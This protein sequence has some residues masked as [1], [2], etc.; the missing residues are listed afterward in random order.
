MPAAKFCSSRSLQSELESQSDAPARCQLSTS[1]HGA[2]SHGPRGRILAFRKLFPG[3]WFQTFKFAMVEDLI[4]SPPFT[5][6]LS[7]LREKGEMWDGPLVPHLAAPGARQI[8]RLGEGQQVAVLHRASLPPLL[9]LHL[10]PED[11]FQK[12]I[13]RAQQPLPFEDLPVVD[14]DLT[15]VAFLHVEGLKTLRDWRRRAVGALKELQR[16]WS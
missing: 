12:A 9:P 11:D 16:R 4:K 13:A 5:S 2:S 1:R 3:T 7:W 6:F 14:P 8:S 15:F 10:E